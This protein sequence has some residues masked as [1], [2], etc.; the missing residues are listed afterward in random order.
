MKTP[1]QIL[2][3]ELNHFSEGHEALKK[4]RWEE[5]L[6]KEKQMITNAWNNAYAIGC[7]NGNND[8]T[9][10]KDTDNAEQY[11]NETFKQ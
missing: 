8:Y 5:L 9:T 2:L 10:E 1:M 11:F 3:S 7:C 6:E 4:T